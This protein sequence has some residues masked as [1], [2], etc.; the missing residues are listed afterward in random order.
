MKKKKQ[1]KNRK[2][3]KM[4]SFSVVFF[5]S[6]ASFSTCLMSSAL[7]MIDSVRQGDLGPLQEGREE[8]SMEGENH[9]VSVAVY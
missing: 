9:C 7:L 2:E 4:T 8:K 5:S 6:L 3:K 1:K